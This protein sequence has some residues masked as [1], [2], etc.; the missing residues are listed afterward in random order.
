MYLSRFKI[1]VKSAVL[2]MFQSKSSE[3]YIY[4]D[5]VFFM[6]VKVSFV[7]K[8]CDNESSKNS[9]RDRTLVLMKQYIL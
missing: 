2:Y 5:A 9:Q 7:Q 1:L 6:Y 3:P 8:Y 4:G